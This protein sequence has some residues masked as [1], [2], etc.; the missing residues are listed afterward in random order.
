MT[1]L[2]KQ[3]KKYVDLKCFI[4]KY[5]QLFL[6]VGLITFS[7]SESKQYSGKEI[8]VKV[9][10][11]ITTY[12]ADTDLSSVHPFPRFTFVDSNRLLAHNMVRSSLDTLFFESDSLRI[13]EGPYY[14]SDG[15]RKIEN[16]NNLVSTTQGLG[17]VIRMG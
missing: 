10:P 5:F 14:D 3:K 1:H 11:K 7:C 17:I 2:T 13:K 9:G 12:Y 8:Q 6:I 15:P 16:F 4:F